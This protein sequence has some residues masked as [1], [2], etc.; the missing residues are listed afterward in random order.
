[1]TRISLMFATIILVISFSFLL[2]PG[3]RAASQED[4]KKAAEI[5]V[6]SFEQAVQEFDFDKADSFLAPDAR[7]IENSY[8]GPVEPGLR[9]AFQR[10]KDAKVRIDY[11]PQDAE[12]HV[13][14][15]VAWVTITLNSTWDA[16]PAGALSDGKSKAHLIFVESEVLVRTPGGWKIV[17]GHTT[18]LPAAFGVFPDLTHQHGGMKFYVVPGGVA[19][20]AGFK[21]GDVMVD[22]GGQKIDGP[23]DFVR[24]IRG[25]AIGDRVTVTVMR[26]E[27]KITKDVTLDEAK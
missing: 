5:V 26:G 15:D 1:M 18:R 8:P 6:R 25:H 7:W 4:D 10:Y 9:R 24:I 21:T 19:D 12:V 16:G 11:H 3:V 27:E 17:L 13:S 14:G 20:K 22:F 23:G 2:A